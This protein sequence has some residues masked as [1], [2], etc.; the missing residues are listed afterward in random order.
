[1]IVFRLLLFSSCCLHIT[2]LFVRRSDLQ[3]K[4]R[5]STFSF[6]TE[7][8]ST[9]L[10]PPLLKLNSVSLF[11]LSH[12]EPHA[13]NPD[14][15]TFLRVLQSITG[16]N[17]SYW[18]G[19]CDSTFLNVVT[20]V[21][22]D[23]AITSSNMSIRN[24][25]ST[26]L[27]QDMP[28]FNFT[29]PKN[30][31]FEKGDSLWIEYTLKFNFKLA[32]F[33]DSSTAF[34]YVKSHLY[35]AVSSKAFSKILQQLSLDNNITHLV[36]SSSNFVAI[37][38]FVNT[39]QL[40]SYSPSSPSSPP[41][42]ISKGFIDIDIQTVTLVYLVPGVV[43]FMIAIIVFLLRFNENA[44]VNPNLEFFSFFHLTL[45][46]LINIATF[47]SSIVFVLFL[48]KQGLT[49]FGNLI[50]SKHILCVGFSLLIFIRC[51]CTEKM[52]R[53]FHTQHQFFSA[54][55][56]IVTIM[57]MI[58]I[59]NV[60][61]LPWNRSTLTN[62]TKGFPTV[63][64]MKLC[65]FTSALQTGLQFLCTVGCFLLFTH[66]TPLGFTTLLLPTIFSGLRCVYSLYCLHNAI[67][68][69]SR[70]NNSVVV[71]QGD[72]MF[73]DIQDGEHQPQQSSTTTDDSPHLE[74]Y[75]AHINSCSSTTG[76][77]DHAYSS[78]TPTTVAILVPPPALQVV[79]PDSIIMTELI[80][81]GPYSMVIRGRFQDTDVAV[82]I[83]RM[84]LSERSKLRL[85]TE[86]TALA[87]LRHS[88]ITVLIAICKDV[89]PLEGSF[90]VVT[91]FMTNKSL[92]E[93]LHVHNIQNQ[94]TAL[95]RIQ[96]HIQRVR[97]ALDIARGM[98]F[99][100]NHRVLHRDL[101][102]GNIVIDDQGRALVS[103]YGL[104][105]Y[106]KTVSS[107]SILTRTIERMALSW[108][109]PEVFRGLHFV[110]LPSDV[111][112]FGVVLW[113]IFTRNIPWQGRSPTEIIDIVGKS[114]QH[115]PI[116]WSCAPEIR[117]L[118]EK[119]F[120]RAATRCTFIEVCDVLENYLLVLEKK[121][122]EGSNKCI[123][124]EVHDRE[125]EEEEELEGHRNE[126]ITL[127][128]QEQ[129]VFD[130]SIVDES[131]F[132]CP[133][134]YDIMI[135]PVICAD[136]HSYDRVN[137]E[138]WLAHHN[139]SPKTNLPISNRLLFPNHDLREA[140]QLYLSQKTKISQTTL[141]K[142]TTSNL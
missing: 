17:I 77:R 18:N 5:L 52:S 101:R 98:K 124:Q 2:T 128:P 120:Q 88:N 123:C 93:A 60:I 115:L 104:D 24:I 56:F 140:I 31:E 83:F 34:N 58:E 118:L 59:T 36:N 38:P 62:L 54:I 30:S 136:G 82:K 47:L 99:L 135:D 96:S 97:I 43:S 112:S 76:N 94:S 126:Y 4:E 6:R 65:H 132:L 69:Q 107:L 133:I 105:T 79:S 35:D 130:Q 89:N 12:V 106:R 49:F 86:L 113:E 116:P 39:S 134:G 131:P 22:D 7:V 85:V 73:T 125:E 20:T 91:R 100:H 3:F 16:V 9:T 26:C 25:T 33:S 50:I 64:F 95:F 48:W 29:K 127:P 28:I 139:T 129:L 15:S 78:I 27:H 10:S 8:N 23:I 141:Q 46:F 75:H 121:A 110:R 108:T 102:S 63:W 45:D 92:F 41:A 40:P 138:K 90:A 44:E 1:M 119:C 74:A 81:S 87:A 70:L 14:F 142:E 42:L 114:S 137:I 122:V 80:K 84:D 72:V 13:L 51:A 57:M 71:G 19:A 21:I 55:C 68:I 109:A 103:D 32:G 11:S 111:Y 66:L 37:A 117:L 67:M 53:Y 61:Y